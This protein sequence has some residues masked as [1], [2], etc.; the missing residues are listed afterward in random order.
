MEKDS[1]FLESRILTEQIRMSYR[2]LH[3]AL[4]VSLLAALG[5]I[6]ALSG[7]LN[8]T[9]LVVWYAALLFTGF[10]RVVS[11]KKIMSG[12]HSYS[13]VRRRAV[14]Y[15]LTALIMGLIWGMAAFAF[16]YIAIEYQ[17][18]V[19]ILLLAIA[20][21]ALAS[22]ASMVFAYYGYALPIL[23]CLAV[24]SFLFATRA[25]Y[26]IGGVI[27]IYSVFIVMSGW[28]LSNSL[29]ESIILR[30]KWEEMAND[31]EVAHSDLDEELAERI[32]AE[33]K[34]KNVKYELEEAVRHLEHLSAID[35]LTGIANRRSFDAAIAREWSRA[36]R[37]SRS[38]ALM[39]IDVDHFK[40]FNDIYHHQ[41]G[42]EA[43]KAVARVISGFAKRPGDL[44]A[45]YGGEEFVLILSN[46]TRDY[47]SSLAEDLR[48]AI[49]ALEIE[50]SGSETNKYL[51]VSIGSALIDG[52][53]SDDYSPVIAAADEAL[54]EAKQGGRNQVRVAA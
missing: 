48:Q 40:K 6:I 5:V 11:V 20:G 28:R 45:R 38:I 37:D 49:M 35:A 16:P 44:A 2:Q 21:G 9:L 10:L 17:M 32:K 7:T 41:S 22:N 23:L 26:I 8:N 30:F 34:L 27:M 50:H 25:W 31:L 47:V 19:L 39:M 24:Q 4:I 15:S 18:I 51:T 36:R 14:Y 33:S 3:V 29:R 54:Y 52:P 13:I 1:K 53:E 42:D 43:L 46:A 12:L